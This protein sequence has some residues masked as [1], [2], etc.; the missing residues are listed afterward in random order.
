MQNQ[1]N[2]NITRRALTSK[3]EELAR[4]KGLHIDE[5]ITS[6]TSNSLQQDEQEREYV[7]AFDELLIEEFWHRCLFGDMTMD[8]LLA[9]NYFEVGAFQNNLGGPINRLFSRERWDHCPTGA[10]D[11]S[12][13]LYNLDGTFCPMEPGFYDLVWD[14]LQPT[15]QMATRMFCQEDPFFKAI[16]DVRNWYDAR[17]T[18]DSQAQGTAEP[19][20]RIEIRSDNNEAIGYRHNVKP[21]PTFNPVA[22][23]FKV[24]EEKLQLRIVTAHYDIEPP[25]GEFKVQTAVGG[26][27][28]DLSDRSR[29]I[30]I[31]LCAEIVWQLMTSRYSSSE[32][33]MISWMLSTTIVHELCYAI[34]EA[35][36]LW[37][38]YP[39][40]Y[41]VTDPVDLR[42]CELLLKEL[43]I[44]DSQYNSLEPYYKDDSSNE[45][46]EAFE[47]HVLGQSP[48]PMAKASSCKPIF[49]SFYG[50]LT[51][52]FDQSDTFLKSTKQDG[53]E[54]P[55]KLGELSF[56]FNPHTT[57]QTFFKKEFWNTTFKKYGSSALKSAPTNP[58]KVAWFS[59]V[60]SA[61]FYSSVAGLSFGSSEFRRRACSFIWELHKSGQQVIAQYL[62]AL[63]YDA[64]QFAML[65]KRFVNFA[66]KWYYRGKRLAGFVANTRMI[67]LEA[68]TFY[69]HQNRGIDID[70][71]KQ[72]ASTFHAQWQKLR[73]HRYIEPDE[74]SISLKGPMDQFTSAICQAEADYD[75]RITK[76][77][78][79]FSH[80][81]H[82]ELCLQETMAAQL[83]ELPIGFWEHYIHGIPGH[84]LIWKARTG[85]IIIQLTSLLKDLN[86]LQNYLPS[87]RNEWQAKILSWLTS[88]QNI[89]TLIS[90]DAREVH[91]NW[92]EMFH[93]VPM[94]RKSRRKLWERWYFLAK[95]AILN[96]K[97][98]QL[99]KLEE[100]EN[101]YSQEFDLNKYKM[102]LP[103]RSANEQGIA[104]KWAGLLN[105]IVEFER[106]ESK[107]MEDLGRE[108]IQIL[109]SSSRI[110]SIAAKMDPK[111]LGQYRTREIRHELET[112]RQN[113]RKMQLE[114]TESYVQEAFERDAP[115]HPMW[116]Y[117]LQKAQK[118]ARNPPITSTEPQITRVLMQD[119][120]IPHTSSENRKKRTWDLCDNSLDIVETPVRKRRPAILPQRIDSLSQAVMEI[121]NSSN[122]NVHMP[123]GRAP[124]LVYRD[125]QIS[126][127][128]LEELAESVQQDMD[129]IMSD[130]N[131]DV[132]IHRT[133]QLLTT[134]IEYAMDEHTK[135]LNEA[136]EWQQK[137][138][139]LAQEE[140]N[141]ADELQ[142]EEGT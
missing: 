55:H 142:G 139:E 8:E 129:V 59:A 109:E 41:G 75:K 21:S 85:K 16:L 42:F 70:H 23:T 32:K 56:T 94:L 92:R 49:L 28:Y 44:S 15:L 24:L 136:A 104:E 137:A 53:I 114:R 120:P 63:I 76:S 71:K 125:I 52:S 62:K 4:K 72:V 65:A 19:V 36:L 39:D 138:H 87:W 5:Y 117:Q 118:A 68:G 66:E 38:R 79:E 103:G 7:R 101:L 27:H 40:D 96:L 37:I 2:K 10:V 12:A 106:D 50:G 102:I 86:G 51:S 130:D 77:L 119:H 112:I 100:F 57:I 115:T 1:P 3:L 58:L 116:A 99:A 29:S 140:R 69:L 97:G 34:I 110:T 47:R 14:S 22:L 17:S 73:N 82:Q 78:M 111:V 43:Y 133:N 127:D 84:Q 45:I 48:F 132:K 60:E 26:T 107:L 81:L 88:F 131:E 80:H 18:I 30:C 113:E 25:I 20:I 134:K 31:N 46:G 83:Y 91:I 90:Q 126:G 123:A 93:T 124:K 9:G 64:W 98:E 128:V 105:N 95:R 13:V 74:V 67:A 141:K 135:A 33:T 54:A 122:G 61:T 11:V 121:S 89:L 35:T 108:E 6:Q